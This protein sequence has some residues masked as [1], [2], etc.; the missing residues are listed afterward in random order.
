MTDTTVIEN[1]DIPENPLTIEVADQAEA[2][3]VE[4]QSAPAEAAGEAEAE[5]VNPRA[6]AWVQKR[7]AQLAADKNDFKA[8]LEASE[9]RNA[10]LAQLAGHPAEEGAER[11]PARA[12]PAAI[13][14]NEVERRAAELADARA[15]NAKANAVFDAGLKAYG[16]DFQSA[17]ENLQQAGVTDPSQTPFV[18]IALEQDNPEALIRH[19]G[20][21][22]DEAIRIAGLAPFKQASEMAKL[23]MKLAA[24]VQRPISRVAAPETPIAAAAKP[25]FDF[26]DTKTSSTDEWIRRREQQLASR[27]S[28]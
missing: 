1:D 4:A 20:N 28:H 17:V 12:E 13:P 21:N 3:V 19:L 8:R 15:F 22:P 14:A 25:E 11:P 6:P 9:A 10:V 7:I 16:A 2:P 24:P 27:T 26:A 23:S 5:K 18:A